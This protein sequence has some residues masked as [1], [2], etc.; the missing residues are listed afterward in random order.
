M[1]SEDKKRGTEHRLSPGTESPL[2]IIRG[3]N[4]SDKL[5]RYHSG[6]YMEKIWKRGRS[7][8]MTQDVRYFSRLS[9][10]HDRI[11]VD[12]RYNIPGTV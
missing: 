10:V 11:L 8:E 12:E 9:K 3:G 2:L 1:L 5:S 6:R 4:E 7:E